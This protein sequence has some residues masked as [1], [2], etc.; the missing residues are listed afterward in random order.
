MCGRTDRALTAARIAVYPIDARGVFAPESVNDASV[1]ALPARMMQAPQRAASEGVYLADQTIQQVAAETGGKAFV[2]S[3]RFQE[4][5]QQAFAD[6]ANYYTIGYT[7]P[8]GK[9]DGQ[10]RKIKVDVNGGYELSY[11]DGYYADSPGHGGDS[12][13]STMKEA[14][15]FGAPP[16]SD[17]PFKV[18]VIPSTDPA[19]KGFMP[20]LD[21][22]R[23]QRQQDLKLPL[24]RY[25]IDYIVDAHHFN[26]QKTPDGVVHARPAF[27]VLAYDPDGKVINI[28]DHALKS[29]Y[30]LQPTRRACPAA[31]P[32]TRRSTC[33]RA[34]SFCASWCVN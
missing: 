29:I 11:R 30:P 18:R 34:S 33:P 15:E 22:R 27:T 25:L 8:Q 13:A 28:T 23:G 26:F 4:A 31:F 12:G 1:G 9:D 32:S 17:I 5:I 7:P 19:A 6:S 2:N 3:N 24:T 16:P 10:F 21:P 14:V 20:T